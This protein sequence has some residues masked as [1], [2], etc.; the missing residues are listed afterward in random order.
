MQFNNRFNKKTKGFTLMEVLIV[1]LIGAVIMV[2]VTPRIAKLFGRSETT[3]ETQNIVD[4]ISNI[5]GMRD[6]GSYG[7]SGTN[8][9]PQLIA[10]DGLPDSLN[11]NSGVVTNTWGGAVTAVSTGIGFTLSYAAPMP[12]AACVA[13]ATKMSNSTIN[14]TKINGGSAVTGRVSQAQATADCA[15]STANT[16]VFTSVN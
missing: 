5:K 1:L 10:N 12:Q 3:F 15:A 7:A 9:I 11:V 2:L 6:Q 14:T 16:I 8:L 13:I 4:L